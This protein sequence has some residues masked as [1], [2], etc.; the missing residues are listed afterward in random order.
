M[1]NPNYGTH[2]IRLLR[3]YPLGVDLAISAALPGD[4]APL[5]HW[6]VGSAAGL[7][8]SER[9]RFRYAADGERCGGIAGFARP[10]PHATSARLQR[11]GRYA[12]EK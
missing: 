6:K 10:P 5:M 11:G 7:E 1:E 3:H 12:F 8:Y 4:W 2:A 9:V